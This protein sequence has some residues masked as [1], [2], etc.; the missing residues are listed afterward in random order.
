[1]TAPPRKREGQ[2]TGPR[3]FNGELLDVRTAAALIGV[4]EKLIRSRVERR[5]IPFRRLGGRVVFLRDELTAYQQNLPGC[6]LDE[7]LKNLEQRNEASG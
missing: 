7:A 4:T 3:R 2:A 5:C 6:S 1:M